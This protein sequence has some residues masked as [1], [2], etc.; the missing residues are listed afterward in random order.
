MQAELAV[1]I[2]VI[3]AVNSMVFAVSSPSNRMVVDFGL[4]VPQFRLPDNHE[5]ALR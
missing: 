4:I 1:E 3:A 5:P 2:T